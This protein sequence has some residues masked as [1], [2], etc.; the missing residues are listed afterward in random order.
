MT[1]QEDLT[2]LR[3]TISQKEQK[4]LLAKAEFDNSATDSDLASLAQLKCEQDIS[5]LLATGGHLTQPQRFL[6]LALQRSQ[7]KT[8]F[9]NRGTAK[10][11]ADR[12]QNES[13][14]SFANRLQLLR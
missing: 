1:G 4:F 14:E 11:L 9:E 13:F 3:D 8:E 12:L 2:R 7:M 5:A 6:E 10:I